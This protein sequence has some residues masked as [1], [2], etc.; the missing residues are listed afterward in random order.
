MIE[1]DVDE[2]SQALAGKSDAGSNQVCVETCVM[3]S[4]DQVVQISAR[5]RLASCQVHV[6]DT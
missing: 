1:T 2:F 4:G 5:Q 6:Q 3:G